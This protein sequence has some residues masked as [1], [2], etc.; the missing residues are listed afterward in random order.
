M[1][2]RALVCLLVG[3]LLLVANARL[4]SASLITNLVN[5]SNELKD[6]SAAYV[7][8]SDGKTVV[9][10]GSTLVEGDIIVGIINVNN[11]ITT[12][13]PIT[14]ALDVVFAFQIT[15]IGALGANGLA[16][17][18]VPITFGNAPAGT[19]ALLLTGP[20]YSLL[21]TTL[22]ADSFA[23]VSSPVPG[24]VTLTS[25][26]PTAAAAFAT[27]SSSFSLDAAGAIG[28]FDQAAINTTV[29]SSTPGTAVGTEQGSV[30][31]NYSPGVIFIPDV[32]ESELFSPFGSAT[33]Q[34]GFT[35]QLAVA[36]PPQLAAGWAYQDSSQLYVDA[37]IIPEP[38]TLSVWLGA[39]LVGGLLLRRRLCRS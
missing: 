25:N 31:I 33:N 10:P 2:T 8:Q 18:Q 13:K 4:A 39:F 17:N 38:A 6:N 22:S 16:G 20:Q 19:L 24:D 36:T 5:G 1:K 21:T 30:S 32:V 12:G 34:G 27:L 14:G 7:T 11:N 35:S 3:G 37:H 26:S 9:P 28:A 23:F 29:I 15:Y